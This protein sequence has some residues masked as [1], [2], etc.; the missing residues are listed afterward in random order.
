[1][2]RAA[3]FEHRLAA[4]VAD[5]GVMR[6]WTSWY[7]QLPPDATASL[8]S[9][10]REEFDAGVAAGLSHAP[11]AVRF[12]LAKRGEPYG[13]TS[14]YDILHLVK[15]YDL[16]G[17][18][19]QIRCPTLVTDP[20]DEAFWPGQAEELHAAL[21][22]PKTLMRFTAAEGASGHCAPLAATLFCQRV[23]DWLEDTLKP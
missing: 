2:P 10:T 5:P 3:A 20:E 22:C 1:M 16:T 23:F 12:D 19:D 15:T 4:A 8:G 7:D 9:A 21:T 17:V 11:A 14:L 18:A 6:V 13:T